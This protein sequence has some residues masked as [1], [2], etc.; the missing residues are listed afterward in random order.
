MALKIELIINY[1]MYLPS[2]YLLVKQRIDQ[3]KDEYFLP[4]LALRVGQLVPD[5]SS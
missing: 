5:G 4:C 1:E 2:G 3:K